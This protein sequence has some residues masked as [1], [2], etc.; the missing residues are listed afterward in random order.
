MYDQ[1]FGFSDKPFALT[2]DFRFFYKSQPHKR[3]MAYLEYG[4]EQS[5]GF[6]VITGPVGIGK[7]TLIEGLLEGIDSN[8]LLAVHLVS[9]NLSGHDLLRLVCQ[10]LGL[11]VPDSASKSQLLHTME[12]RLRAVQKGGQRV[13]LVVDEA[14]NLAME[15][16]EELRMLSNFRVGHQPMIQSFLIGQEELRD[17]LQQPGLEQFRQ[18]I[19]AA[20]HLT[21]L[22]QDETRGYIHH[23]LQQVG[24]KGTPGIDPEVFEQ[25]QSYTGGIPRRINQVCDRLLLACYLEGQARIDRHLAYSVLC[26]LDKEMGKAPTAYGQP[27]E[28][29][30]QQ[31]VEQQAGYTSTEP[32]APP[33]TLQ[34]SQPSPTTSTPPSPSSP[35]TAEQK[36]DYAQP[37]RHTPP[38][39]D[40]S[41]QLFRNNL[42]ELISYLDQEVSRKL[43]KLKALDRRLEKKEQALRQQVVEKLIPEK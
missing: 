17:N 40:D 29:T 33:Q 5:E 7:T 14:Q 10:H 42:E 20:C 28:Q 18:R 2:P 6:I 39:M 37:V 43:K 41:A 4:L 36:P 8:S 15:T 23:R 19:I 9:T 27:A 26:E 25:I 32:V 1:H 13:I 24:W 16:L 35:V 30:N 22:C 12:Q 38:S 34:P 21:P 11:P 31:Q 3:A